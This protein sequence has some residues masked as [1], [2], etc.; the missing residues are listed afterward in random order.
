MT[1][2]ITVIHN[3]A[4]NNSDNLSFYPPDNH[5]RSDTVQWRRG[6][7]MHQKSNRNKQKTLIKFLWHIN[8]NVSRKGLAIIYRH[9]WTVQCMHMKLRTQSGHQVTASYGKG[10]L[11][12]CL[13]LPDCHRLWGVACLSALNLILSIALSSC[14]KIIPN[15][16]THQ[17]SQVTI[18][19]ISNWQLWTCTFAKKSQQ[20]FSWPNSTQNFSSLVCQT[21]GFN[22]DLFWFGCAVH[23][24]AIIIP[25]WTHCAC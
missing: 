9:N 11:A 1:V 25:S 12:V 5:Y 8:T 7:A 4:Q 10:A 17:V 13:F 23:A 22:W 15:V 3:T 2:H 16:T 14:M 6:E 19:L 21:Y 20:N 18:L 24:R